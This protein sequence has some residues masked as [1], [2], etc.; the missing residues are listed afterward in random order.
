MLI[1]TINIRTKYISHLSLNRIRIAVI[2]AL[3]QIYLQSTSPL[4]LSKVRVK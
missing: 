1:V 4:Y 2:G 3:S